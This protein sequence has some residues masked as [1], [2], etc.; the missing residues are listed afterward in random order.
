MN[1]WTW[2]GSLL[3]KKKTAIHLARGALGE[4]AARKFLLKKGMAFLVSNIRT[5]GSEIDLVFRESDC[6]VFVEVKTRSG[7]EWNRP[8][9][10]VDA[11]KRRRLSRA[12]ME[13]LRRIQNPKTRLR[14]DIVEVLLENGAVKEIRHLPN[15][16]AL[17]HPLR[18]G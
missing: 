7:E 12:A 5:Q 6:L 15:A 13:Y 17:A 1:L 10:A 18:Y 11:R 4:E 3:R 2:L 14:F 8:A 9:A 16:F